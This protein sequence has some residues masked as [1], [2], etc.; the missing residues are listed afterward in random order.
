MADDAAE[1]VD[2]PAGD[3]A[4]DSDGDADAADLDTA[5][6]DAV[7]EQQ[8]EVAGGRQEGG[9]RAFD[10]NRPFS[11][12]RTFEKNLQ[13]ICESFVKAAGLGFTNHFRANTGVEFQGIELCAYREF[14][15]GLANPTCVSTV[16]LA[17]LKGQAV[18]NVDIGLMFSIMKK[19][20]G[21]AIEAEV[22][23]RKFTDIEMNVAQDVLG[24]LLDHF[25]TG[26]SRM[27]PITPRLLATENNPAYLSA[28][29]SGETVLLL[30][31]VLT[32]DEIAGGVTFAIPLAAFESVRDVLDPEDLPELR[33]A[34]EVRRDR[35]CVLDLLQGT[36]A[37]VVVD[38]GS[39]DLNLR[40][41][42]DLAVGDMIQL[43]TAVGSPLRLSVQGK[44]VF[45]SV[46]GKLNKN[47][48][49]RLTERI[50]EED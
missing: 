48:A 35:S 43:E 40:R 24:K 29:P 15:A 45:M 21:G 19:L 32:L 33:S 6:I 31:F 13:S 46:P 17:P 9:V 42:R 7:L 4:V 38:L 25:R 11:I 12:T 26:V 8:A 10:F 47:R 41:I 39:V 3:P 28:L 27:I 22:D 20:L 44:P 23:L 37:E 2:R 50:R 5:A 14:H 49:V 1:T 18:V 34:E 36:T 16:T 30:E